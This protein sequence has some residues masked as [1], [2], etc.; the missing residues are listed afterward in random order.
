LFEDAPAE[1]PGGASPI[2]AAVAVH[3]DQLRR[4]AALPAPESMRL[5][6]AAESACGLIA[7]EMT[8]TGVPWRPDVHDAVLTEL[9]GPRPPAG[10]RPRRLVELADRIAEA[11]GGRRVNPDHPAV[12][13]LLEYKELSRLYAA[14]GWSWLDTWVSGGRFRPDWV[15][16]GVV[17]GR[18]ASRGGGALQIPHALRRAVIA[19]PGHALVVADA[20]QLEPR[21][22]AVLAGD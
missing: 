10:M 7:A 5:L 1:L 22:L 16:G 13:P 14:N 2:D 4:L 19:E 17:S 18:W 15:V 20:A 9:L 11:F 3:A 12:A 21:I 8:R 6:V